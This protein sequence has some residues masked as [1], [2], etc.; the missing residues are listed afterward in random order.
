[1]RNLRDGVDRLLYIEKTMDI[2]PQTP[3]LWCISP[4]LIIRLVRFPDW[5]TRADECQPSHGGTTCLHLMTSIPFSSSNLAANPHPHTCPPVPR[6]MQCPT[7]QRPPFLPTPYWCLGK[8]AKFPHCR[9]LVFQTS[10][11]RSAPIAKAGVGAWHAS[12]AESRCV[13]TVYV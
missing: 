10:H 6:Y 9:P 3:T 13:T 7:P 4:S 8:R 5:E 11:A 12:V 1:M 2:C